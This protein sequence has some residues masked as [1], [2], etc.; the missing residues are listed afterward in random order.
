MGAPSR[1]RTLV[2]EHG[3]REDTVVVVMHGDW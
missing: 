3:M 1:Q 2:G